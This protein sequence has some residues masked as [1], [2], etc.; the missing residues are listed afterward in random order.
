MLQMIR[1]AGQGFH[2]SQILLFMGL[3][4]Q[5]K[6]N[7]DLIRAMSGLAGGLGFTGDTCGALTGGACLLGLYAG[8]GTPEEQEDEKLNLMIS[9]LVDWFSEE[10]GKL[11]GGIRCDIILGDDPRNRTTRCPN[12]VLG[13]YGKVKTLLSEY[14]FDLSGEK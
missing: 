13:S 9:E 2:C 3:E 4:A 11:Y 6:S 10:Y 7:P 14:G 1:L 8:R 12:M 5:G